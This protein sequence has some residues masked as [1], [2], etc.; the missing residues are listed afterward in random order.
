MGS[1]Q[2][3]EG[4]RRWRSNDGNVHLTP[5]ILKSTLILALF[6][7]ATA[8]G[9]EPDLAPGDKAAVD[10]LQK[11]AADNPREAV[12]L[13]QLAATYARVGW[14]AKSLAA[15]D[16]VLKLKTGIQPVREFGWDVLWQ[17][18]AFQK[19]LARFRAQH[20]PVKRAVVAYRGTDAE[21]VPEGLAYDAA[22]QR[23]L[24]GSMYRSKVVA[25]ER[26]GRWHDLVK[27]RPD[28]VPL[29]MKVIADEL[30]VISQP[31]HVFRFDARD[32]RQIAKMEIK[33][34]GI[35]LNDL[36]P[37]ASGEVFVTDTNRGSVYR[38][39]RGAK[40]LERVVPEGAVRWCNGIAADDAGKALFVANWRGIWRFGPEGGK[41]VR[42]N[43]PDHISPSG[44]DGLYFYKGSLIGVQNTSHAGRIVRWFLNPG[45][46]AIVREEVLESGS[47]HF[48]EPT[49]G[50]VVG[51]EFFFIANSYVAALGDDG[52]IRQAARL[53][54]TVIMKVRLG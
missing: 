53:K 38:I 15:L 22:R 50:A 48:A 37:I 40:A 7:A 14:K 4:P 20:P 13:L 43:T 28:F 45:M 16:E 10:A 9:Q 36:Q 23:L 5:F 27:P 54:P 3:L 2:H 31:R 41:P 29:G 52:K 19:L 46:D 49:T 47:E 32:G 25:I 26:D 39:A 12:V 17:D 21:L 42:L 6:C 33:D 44:V 1:D 18:A 51:D 35:F 11:L 30:W 34:E 8:W 24:L